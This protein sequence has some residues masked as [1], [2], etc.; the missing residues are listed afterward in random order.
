MNRTSVAS[1]DAMVNSVCPTIDVTFVANTSWNSV[2][3]SSKF[4]SSLLLK[5][6]PGTTRCMYPQSP[7][8]LLRLRFHIF[9]RRH[10]RHLFTAAEANAP[11]LYL[12][13]VAHIRDSK[14]EPSAWLEQVFL[15]YSPSWLVLQSRFDE[16]IRRLQVVLYPC[17]QHLLTSCL[18]RLV[19][20]LEEAKMF[21]VT[22]RV[23]TTTLLL[24]P[25]GAPGAPSHPT[26]RRLAEHPA[27]AWIC[28]WS[29]RRTP[30]SSVRFAPRQ[31]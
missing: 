4:W 3:N 13:L 7:R 20:W 14:K 17:R 26:R 29:R 11:S 21:V 1:V 23:Y 19:F 12:V 25:V 2:I 27:P 28:A 6:A 15:Q 24:G 30:K 8:V 5:F 10:P 16:A 22:L 9:Y 31:L 18:S